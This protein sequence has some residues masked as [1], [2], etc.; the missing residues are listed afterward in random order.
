MYQTDRPRL[1]D[2]DP[3][4]FFNPEAR[5]TASQCRTCHFV[6]RCDHNAAAIGFT[7]GVSGVMLPGSYPRKPAACYEALMRQLEERRAIELPHETVA[8]VAG[9]IQHRRRAT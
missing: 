6:G 3:E 8:G 7:H 2:R 1:S 4:L 5:R 9:A